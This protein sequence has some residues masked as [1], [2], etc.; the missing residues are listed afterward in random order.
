[1][2][3]KIET[4]RDSKKARWMA[5][6]VVSLAMFGAYFFNYTLSP[7]K[8]MLESMLGWNSADFGIYTSSYTW[9]NVFLFMLIFSGIILDKMG[10]RF[11]GLTATGLMALGTGVNYWALIH[12]FPAGSA[13]FGS[14]D[15]AATIAAMKA[16]IA[17]AA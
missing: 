11:T 13:I 6:V 5:L 7:L 1:M 9:F 10:I 12:T 15:Y 16:N 4:L 17:K 8:P 3:D 14:E 2:T